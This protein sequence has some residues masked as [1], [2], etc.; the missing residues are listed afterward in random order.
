MR[1]AK[2]RLR[3]ILED[4]GYKPEIIEKIVDFYLGKRSETK[5]KA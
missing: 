5:R 1:D 3:R 2:V 4:N